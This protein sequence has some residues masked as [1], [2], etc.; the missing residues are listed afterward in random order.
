LGRKEEGTYSGEKL[1]G[2][3]EEY[4]SGG[5][6]FSRNDIHLPRGRLWGEYSSGKGGLSGEKS[7]N[8]R[9]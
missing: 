7:V 3:V 6:T 9:K 8:V 4:Y 2:I 1:Y 5:I